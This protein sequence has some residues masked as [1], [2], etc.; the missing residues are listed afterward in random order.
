LAIFFPC[1]RYILFYKKNMLC[2][3]ALHTT[4]AWRSWLSTNQLICNSF[5]HINHFTLVWR[6]SRLF[7]LLCCMI[8]L[9]L[10]TTKSLD[11]NTWWF[12]YRKCWFK[13]E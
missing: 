8:L 2:I 3:L 12:F 10:S 1:V 13:W 6:N 11:H 4:E 9:F 7:M 5:Q